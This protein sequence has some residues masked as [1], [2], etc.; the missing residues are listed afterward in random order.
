MTISSLPLKVRGE[1]HYRFSYAICHNVTMGGG[2]GGG[3][4]IYNDS[5]KIKEIIIVLYI[6]NYGWKTII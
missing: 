3:G 4:E 2:G 5:L 1:F 6:F